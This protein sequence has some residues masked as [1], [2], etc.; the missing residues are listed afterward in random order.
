MT[1]NNA[2]SHFSTMQQKPCA[3]FVLEATSVPRTHY[4]ASTNSKVLDHN[5][6]NLTMDP[7]FDPPTFHH[8]Y[9]LLFPIPF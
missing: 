4:P 6:N 8:P 2:L 9:S 7:H 3:E 1:L 5:N